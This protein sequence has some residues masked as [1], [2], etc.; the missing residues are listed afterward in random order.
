MPDC[1]ASQNQHQR[2]QK[3]QYTQPHQLSPA[4]P[5]AG[6]LLPAQ[7]RGTLYLHQRELLID[8]LKTALLRATS[9][10]QCD[11]LVAVLLALEQFH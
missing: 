8:L 1:D 3:N 4:D 10:Q 2:H 9:R 5:L 11:E 7:H 6:Q